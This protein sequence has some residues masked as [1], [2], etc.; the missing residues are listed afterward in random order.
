MDYLDLSDKDNHA[1]ALAVAAI[2]RRNG[3]PRRAGEIEEMVKANKGK[4]SADHPGFQWLD[5]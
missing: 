3:Y 4:I 1:E 2:L 5:K